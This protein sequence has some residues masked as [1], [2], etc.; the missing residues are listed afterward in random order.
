MDDF[1]NASS[2][3]SASMMMGG[4]PTVE[5][6]SK[7]DAEFRRFSLDGSAHRTFE[8]FRALV[9]RLHGL[10]ASGPGA[11]D[12]FRISYVDPKDNDLL[13]INNTDN[14]QVSLGESGDSFA[15]TLPVLIGS[16][17]SMSGSLI[18][19]RIGMKVM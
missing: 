1:N 11:S 15:F 19:R 4:L 12:D 6:K 8:E 3:A 9:G 18:A 10:D 2:A 14:Y 5:V 7:F 16:M 13:P 17:T